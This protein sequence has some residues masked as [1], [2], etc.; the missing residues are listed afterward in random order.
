MYY[1]PRLPEHGSYNTIS[2]KIHLD[3]LSTLF[4]DVYEFTGLYFR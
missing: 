3:L 2:G 1:F 4:V